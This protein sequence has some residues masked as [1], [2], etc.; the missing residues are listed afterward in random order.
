MAEPALLQ[1]II[2]PGLFTCKVFS[3]GNKNFCRLAVLSRGEKTLDNGFGESLLSPEKS[4]EAP[5]FCFPSTVF[6]EVPP[7]PQDYRGQD[8]ATCPWVF[9][10]GFQAA[11]HQS[12][13]HWAAHLS[14]FRSPESGRE[15]MLGGGGESA[16][17]RIKELY[18]PLVTF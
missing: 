3:G 6:L 9:V 17:G 16:R 13:R 5:I 2:G 8:N 14:P 4:Q 12:P 11:P 10:E 18:S 15:K 7:P 1:L